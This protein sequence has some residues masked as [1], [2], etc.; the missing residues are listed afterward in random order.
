MAEFHEQ[1]F[2]DAHSMVATALDQKLSSFQIQL[3]LVA[4]P[5]DDDKRR[6]TM[7]DLHE[8]LFGKF[9]RLGLR[10]TH[11]QHSH[12]L[13]DDPSKKHQSRDSRKTWF[14]I[15]YNEPGADF[16]VTI[17]DA[18]IT[19]SVKRLTLRTV[20][21]LASKVFQPLLQAFASDQDIIEPLKT[22]ERLNKIEFSFFSKFRIG[23][24]K[25]DDRQEFVKNH[26][27]LLQ[28]LGQSKKPDPDA[29]SKRSESIA[30]HSLGLSADDCLRIDYSH[31]AIKKI[32]KSNYVIKIICEAPLN[33]NSSI[34][35]VQSVIGAD[36]DLDFHLDL[37]MDAEV[38]FLEFYKDIILKRFYYNL[39]CSVNYQSI[40]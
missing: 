5:Q 39:L 7:W 29:T 40:D 27:I 32:R 3:S 28:A 10:R 35:E 14:T 19:I 26:E 13:A 34:L 36:E 1:F 30:F 37:S 21:M 6:R 12:D 18:L 17:S 8:G 24:S 2:A 9:M 4:T 16:L 31:L 22:V 25:D 15:L 33:E 23:R 11:F 20:V 38:P